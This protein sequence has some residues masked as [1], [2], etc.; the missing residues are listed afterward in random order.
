MPR[1]GTP[2]SPDTSGLVYIPATGRFIVVDSEVDETT[3]AGHNEFNIWEYDPVSDTVTGFD[4]IPGNDEPTGV[5]Y[6]PDTHTLFVSDD[7]PGQN[8]VQMF[9]LGSDQRFQATDALIDTIDLSSMTPAANDVEDPT[10]DPTTGHL[11][12]MSGGDARIYEIDPVTTSLVNTIDIADLHLTDNFEGLA[13]NSVTDHLMVGGSESNTVWEIAKTSPFTPPAIR[14][15][16]ANGVSGLVFV[17]GLAMAPASNGSGQQRLWIPDRGVDNG[18]VPTENDGALFELSFPA[19]APVAPIAVNQSVTTEPDTAK[20][21][22]LQAS[23]GN[24]DPLTYVATDPVHGT[25]NDL[26]PPGNQV[27]YT[28]DVGYL[29]ADSFTFTANDGVSGLSNVATVSITVQ[30]NQNPVLGMITSPRRQRDGESHLHRHR[31]RRRGESLRVLPHR[32]TDR[33]RH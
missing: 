16:N 21:I 7:D 33:S 5:G 18:S 20:P 29:G 31:H 15:I 28:P 26:T 17:S 24:G 9:D 14:T 2:A 8:M 11:F 22:T 32:R 12:V 23:D 19:A 1:C 6:D 25:L 13:Y 4:R 3:G 10:F 27:T 30:P